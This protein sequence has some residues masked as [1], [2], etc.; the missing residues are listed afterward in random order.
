MTGGEPLTYP[1][2]D[3]TLVRKHIY[4]TITRPNLAFSAQ[5]LSHNNNNNDTQSR[6]AGYG[7]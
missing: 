3:R 7:G 6:Q 1:S 5:A 2:L 4:L